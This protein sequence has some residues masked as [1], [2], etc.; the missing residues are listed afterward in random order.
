MVTN[1][2]QRLGI[3]VELG[4][5]VVERPCLVE[6]EV[7]ELVERLPSRL[8]AVAAIGGIWCPRELVTVA[9]EQ[10]LDAFTD[11][12][13]RRFIGG[14]VHGEVSADALNEPRAMSTSFGSA[15]QLDGSPA[16]AS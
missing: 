3:D 14:P 2:R 10:P 6:D 1:G 15:V 13:L 4:P 7:G 5:L 11:G 16:N 9:A 8:R 12:G